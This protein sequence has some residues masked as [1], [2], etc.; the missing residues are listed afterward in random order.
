MCHGDAGVIRSHGIRRTWRGSPLWPH[1][2]A[3]GVF[4]DHAA[5]SGVFVLFRAVVRLVQFSDGSAAAAQCLRRSCRTTAIRRAPGQP[6]Y[7]QQTQPGTAQPATYAAA[8]APPAQA[9]ASEQGATVGSFKSSY[10][11]FLQAFRD[12]PEPDPSASPGYDARAS[13]YPQRPLTDSFKGTSDPSQRPDPSGAGYPQQS[14]VGSSN[15]ANPPQQRAYVPHPPS[16]YSPSGQPYTPPAQPAYAPP[17]AQQNYAAPSA[18]PAYAPRPGQQS[19]AAPPAQQAYSAPAAAAAPAA[20]S[21]YSDSL[22]Y[23]KQSL[24]DVFRGSTE[25]QTVPRPPST[26]TASGQPYT[27][28]Q[29]QG[30]VASAPPANANPTD[31]LPYPK[32][33]LFDIFS[34]K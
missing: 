8:A 24:A 4:G 23:P 5:R 34:S 28:P 18:Q 6:G 32:Q 10:V 27:P 17:P 11:N 2:I 7:A 19:Y 13:I 29:G 25:T 14:L 22:P 15:S 26:Y 33:S 20:Q 21:D 30:A 31:S 16:T 9:P 1:G 12:P 3:W